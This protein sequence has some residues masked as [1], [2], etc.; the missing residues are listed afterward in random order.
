MA[1]SKLLPLV[2]MIVWWQMGYID[3][4]NGVATCRLVSPCRRA[5]FAC[6]YCDIPCCM[7]R[8]TIR[9]QSAPI[10]HYFLINSPV[11]LSTIW[12][13]RKQFCVFHLEIVLFNWALPDTLSSHS[14]GSAAFLILS[15]H[16]VSVN[17]L[18][19]LPLLTAFESCLLPFAKFVLPNSPTIITV[20]YSSIPA[21]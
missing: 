19:L 10:V 3:I 18:K 14:F 7:L 15:I 21:F 12:C 6:A 17:G 2:V 8:Q 20:L 5:T 1:P 13:W 16:I 4:M 11:P 9:T